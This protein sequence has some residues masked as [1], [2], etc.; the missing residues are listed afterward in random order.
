LQLEEEITVKRTI[1]MAIVVTAMF[2][3]ADVSEAARRTRVVRG[4]RVRVTVRPGF[5]IHR[6]L[7]NVIVRTAP[8]VRVAP[9]VYLAPVVFRGVVIASLPP[10]NA[11]VWTEDEN[12][13]RDDG[14]TDFTMNVDRRGSRLLLQ[15]DRGAAQISFAEVVFENGETQ[16]VDFDE[17]VHPRGIYSLLDFKDGRKVDHVRVVA[18]A[19]TDSTRISLHLAS[20]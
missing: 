16:V 3:I 7:P 17:K 6:T 9:R 12:L 13:D 2:S 5:P 11:R 19:A 18:R 20:A 15:I 10:A 8:A 14:W 4:A 1:T